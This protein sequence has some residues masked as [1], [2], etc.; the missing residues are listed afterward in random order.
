MES[1]V[2]K[3]LLALIKVHRRSPLIDFSACPA[4]SNPLM[5]LINMPYHVSSL[6]N[7]HDYSHL[8]S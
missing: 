6:E 8:D 5:D 2:I 3:Y 7:L 1:I 4:A